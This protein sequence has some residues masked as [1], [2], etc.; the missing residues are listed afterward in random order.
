MHGNVIHKISC[1]VLQTCSLS[2]TYKH[3]FISNSIIVICHQLRNF[4]N[5]INA[6]EMFLFDIL[7][8]MQVT[9]GLCVC[10]RTLNVHSFLLHSPI[11]TLMLLKFTQH[12]G[13]QYDLQVIKIFHEKWTNSKTKILWRNTHTKRKYLINFL[14]FS[15]LC[16]ENRTYEFLKR[17][18]PQ[19]KRQ[20]VITS[21]IFKPHVNSFFFS[22]KRKL[23]LL[24]VWN[25]FCFCFV[26]A[27]VFLCFFYS[28]FFWTFCARMPR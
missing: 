11:F 17:Q 16:D 6:H 5:N 8:A 15:F 10:T 13:N 2:H 21:A 1:V 25:I 27:L 18:L 14:F 26:F 22:R 24:Y 20:C 12:T 28:F 7:H 3:I 4:D 23:Y 9:D 19:C